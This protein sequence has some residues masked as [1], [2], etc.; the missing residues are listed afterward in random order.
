MNYGVLSE[1]DNLSWSTDEPLTILS[2]PCWVLVVSQFLDCTANSD[3]ST[4][5][6]GA[7]KLMLISA[8][9][10]GDSSSFEEGVLKVIDEIHW[11]FD[12]NAQA[13]EIFRQATFCAH[14]RVNGCMA[15]WVDL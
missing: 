4:G 2:F 12:T 9:R 10:N 5:D 6:S 13:N 7:H 14:G 8:S 11:V 3:P 1:Q 15:V